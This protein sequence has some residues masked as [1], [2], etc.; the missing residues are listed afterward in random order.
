[1]LAARRGGARVLCGERRLAGP[2]GTEEQ[3]AR[4]ARQATAQQPV[5]RRQPT[6]D[7]FA[8]VGRCM[9]GGDEPRIHL[10]PPAANAAVVI[11]FAHLARAH[12]Q[13]LYP[14]PESAVCRRLALYGDDP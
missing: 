12:L 3:V 4:P 10:E 14:A 6:L 13:H 1:M 2:G 5:E 7:R 11:P 8:R 9:L